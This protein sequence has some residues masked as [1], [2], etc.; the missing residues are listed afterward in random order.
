MSIL[1]L[2]A[3]ELGKKIKAKEITV[4]DA[5]KASLEQIK[6]WSLWFTPM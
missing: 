2:T 6:N 3:V 4:V 1:D 5:V